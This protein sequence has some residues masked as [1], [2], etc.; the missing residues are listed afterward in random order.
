MSIRNLATMLAALVIAGALGLSVRAA[1]A[2]VEQGKQMYAAQKCGLCHSIGDSGNKKGPLDDVGARL[3]AADLRAWVVDA[4]GMADKTK[5]PRKPA[6]KNYDLPTDDVDA[7]V[8]YMA[9]LKK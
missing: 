2:K 6:M 1:D 7:L 4:K 3:S 5:A 9:T 8:A